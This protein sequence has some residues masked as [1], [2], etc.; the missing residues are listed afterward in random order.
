M[1]NLASY[2]EGTKPRF[3]Q[4]SQ[5]FLQALFGSFLRGVDGYFGGQGRLVRI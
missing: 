1:D 2:A 3:S 4:R 5:N